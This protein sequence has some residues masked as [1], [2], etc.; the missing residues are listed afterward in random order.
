MN[1]DPIERNTT[2]ISVSKS[3]TYSITGRDV[4]SIYY[5]PQHHTLFSYKYAEDNGFFLNTSAEEL[6]EILDN[7]K[8]AKVATDETEDLEII[9]VY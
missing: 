1:P 8:A 6:K 5:S 9:D 4:A 2:K 7:T 3:R